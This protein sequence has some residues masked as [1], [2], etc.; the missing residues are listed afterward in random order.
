MGYS[1]DVPKPANLAASVDDKT[2]S[3]ELRRLQA[4]E[5]L[6]DLPRAIKFTGALY[7]IGSPPEIIGTG[8]GMHEAATRGLLDAL[9]Q[10][11]YESISADISFSKRF[12][13][14]DVAKRFIP[15]AAL[16]QVS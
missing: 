14:L 11:H 6:P 8:R 10:E 3:R 1:R 7:S 2:L 9:L 5:S 12:I 4:T 16:K 15:Y 13:N